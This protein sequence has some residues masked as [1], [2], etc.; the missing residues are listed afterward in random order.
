ML[1][2]GELTTA[3]ALDLAVRLREEL[4]VS[5]AIRLEVAPDACLEL[6]VLQ[7]LVSARRSGA[8]FEISDPGGALARPLA[9]A[10]L[11]LADGGSYG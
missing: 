2:E 6:A 4:R 1:L 8:C 9:R 5:P 10:G 7:V 11:D 3:M